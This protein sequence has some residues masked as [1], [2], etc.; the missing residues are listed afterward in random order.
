M[1]AQSYIL[2]SRRLAG[3]G[4]RCP[5]A[6]G[7]TGTRTNCAS[8]DTIITRRNPLGWLTSVSKLGHGIEK[9]EADKPRD[10]AHEIMIMGLRLTDGIDLNNVK[11]LCGP[12]E[13]W[14]DLENVQ[15]F[16]E[17]GWLHY[18]LKDSALLAT[19]HGRLRLDYILSSILA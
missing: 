1:S 5:W 8:R 6:L 15:K 7:I 10:W 18:D 9:K 11:A 13:N 14:L 17:A 12:A 3:S 2:A 19:P 16:V 4:T